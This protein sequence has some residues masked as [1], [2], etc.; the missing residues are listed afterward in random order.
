[1]TSRLDLSLTEPERRLA[2]ALAGRWNDLLYVPGAGLALPLEPGFYASAFIVALEG[3]PALRIS[4]LRIPAFGA[5]LCRIRLEPLA[6]YPLTRFG[7]FFEPERRGMIYAMSGDRRAAAPRPPDQPGWSY[8]GPS[9]ADH[10]RIVSEVR[11]LRERVAGGRGDGAFAWSADR[12]IALTGA[13]GQES[14]FLAR[15]A[16]SEDAVLAVTA[17]LYRALLDPSAPPVPGASP[18]ELLG[19]GDWPGP[20]DV[21]VD[22]EPLMS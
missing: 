9:L 8:E 4:S 5:D 12:G 3:A 14:L 19:Y 22:L 1:L 20:L 7:S 2:A 18:A 15:P 10:L 21:A 11:V 6:S 13:D 17:G 16:E